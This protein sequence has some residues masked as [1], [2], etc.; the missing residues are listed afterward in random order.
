MLIALRR[1][2]LRRLSYHNVLKCVL[3]RMLLRLSTMEVGGK[4]MWLTASVP[5]SSLIVLTHLRSL[6]W[7]HT[8]KLETSS[9]PFVNQNDND[10]LT[11]CSSCRFSF[12]VLFQS[13]LV[14]LSFTHSLCWQWDWSYLIGRR[15]EYFLS[16]LGS[17]T[18][19]KRRNNYA[20]SVTSWFNPARFS[21]LDRPLVATDCALHKHQ[22][23]HSHSLYLLESQSYMQS[24][25][26]EC[27]IESLTWRIQAQ[28]H[29]NS[30]TL[31]EGWT[32][33]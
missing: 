6:V 9:C 3:A 14:G 5:R 1:L 21:H 32:M 4:R 29:N 16:I 2:Q 18:N 23:S 17:T 31:V 28:N 20:S 26:Y 19:N 22:V 15:W 11:A 12:S 27:Y 8:D 30:N 24:R 10:L 13:S 25:R 7:R 33:W